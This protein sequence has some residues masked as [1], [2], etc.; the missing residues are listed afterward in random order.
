M[1]DISDGLGADASHVA[2]SSGCRLEIDLD[3]VP[4][5]EGV[6]EVAG[7]R[8]GGARAGGLG[9]R[10][11]RA[12]RHPAAGSPRGCRERGRGDGHE[13]DRDRLRRRGPRRCPAAPRRRRD[14]A[15]RLRPEARVP[16]RLR[17][18]RLRRLGLGPS[19]LSGSAR[20]ASGSPSALLPA[21]RD[22]AG[23]SIGISGALRRGPR[24]AAGGSDDR[25]A[26][27]RPS[28]NRAAPGTHADLPVAS[29]RTQVV[30]DPQPGVEAPGE[31]RRPAPTSG[32]RPS[33]S[34]PAAARRR[35]RVAAKS[36]ACRPIATSSAEIRVD[37]PDPDR[38][39]DDGE[40]HGCRGGRLGRAR[41]AVAAAGG[42]KNAIVQ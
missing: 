5:A 42:M 18:S 30:P 2:D 14:P 26:R 31:V 7:G 41:A 22:L 12:A 16:L 38:C 8:K 32:S 6:A 3:L 40:Q 11:L 37:D 36:H 4:V 34:S 10:G 24:P 9:R 27:R 19:S 39:R 1:I 28:C 17:L 21:H 25:D 23:R 33:R 13:A 20:A 35:G 15:E 29:I